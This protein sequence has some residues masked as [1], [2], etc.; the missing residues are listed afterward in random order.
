MQ[1]G[2]IEKRITRLWCKTP[3]LLIGPPGVGKT[4]FCRSL[5]TILE[6]ELVVLDCSQSGDSGDLIGLL[7]IENHVHHHTKP[8]WMDGDKP[9]LVFIDEINRA[10]GEVIA[11][12]MKL[13]SPEQSFNGFTLP[14]GSRVVL[15]INPSNVDSNQV[16]PLNRALYTRFARYRVE[17]DANYWLKW[18]AGAG[19][20]PIVCR[21]I[22]GHNN[23]LYV[24]D[25]ELDSEDENTANPRS[26]E[27]FA[28]LFDNAYKAG[29][30]VDAYGNP[31]AG[32][33]E[34]MLIDA[35]STLGPDMAK[36][37]TEWFRKHGN[38]LDAEMVLKAKESDWAKYKG[39][40]DSMSVPQLTKLSDEVITKMDEA[41]DKGK[42][43][44][45][46]SLNFWYFYF[47][48]QPEIRAQMYNFHLIHLVFQI[49][50]NKANWLSLLREHVG[51][52]KKE[53]LKASFSE[54][55]QVN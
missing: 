41:Y 27:N 22:S 21:F 5:A 46:M 47:A 20:N 31:V 23:A 8:D 9:K 51:A 26:W 34:T 35:T 49:S 11:A 4:Q 16:M 48:V 2:V 19:I 6:L 43:S 28:R 42:Q 3:A 15:A 50:D 53:M 12:L 37:F 44:K 30:Y 17:V 29:D 45:E 14:E 54:F 32:G 38:T 40:I 10:K 55:N 1:F 13:C 18:A 36:T 39:I 25:T 52:E 24:D 33:M 7:E